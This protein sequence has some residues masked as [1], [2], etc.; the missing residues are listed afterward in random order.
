MSYAHE[1][2]L[3][4]PVKRFLENQGYRIKGEVVSCDIVGVRGDEPP[5]IV[6]LKLS[7]C[8]QVLY[9]SMDRQKAADIVY[10]AV[11]MPESTAGRRRW[12]NDLPNMLEICRRLGLGLLAVNQSGRIEP[13]VDPGPY[14]PRRCAKRRAALLREFHRRSGDHNIGGSTRR[15]IV[16]GYREEALRLAATLARSGPMKVS[17][18]KSV[19]GIDKTAA[20][21][22]RDVYSWFTRV[23]RGVYTLSQG[24]QTAL[25]TYADVVG[26][27][28]VG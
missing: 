27:L 19:S 16:T 22:Q 15:P 6:E 21:L 18:L 10:V 14:R 23:E 25:T 11:P 12:R 2:E 8:L 24:G 20:I 3:Y 28:A 7:F 26:A 4:A 9:Q 17:A 13:L 5:I 1:T